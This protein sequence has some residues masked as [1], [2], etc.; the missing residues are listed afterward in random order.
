[1]QT[2]LSSLSHSLTVCV[3]CM[4]IPNCHRAHCST[5][6]P[7]FGKWYGSRS[8]LAFW[9]WTNAWRGEWW[10]TLL[11][12]SKHACTDV[13]YNDDWWY[14]YVEP[15][16]AICL[17]V[18]LGVLDWFQPLPC[19][20]TQQCNY[21]LFVVWRL[22]RWANPLLCVLFLFSLSPL[23][24]PLLSA[25]PLSPFPHSPSSFSP[26]PFPSLLSRLSLRRRTSVTSTFPLAVRKE[27]IPC[28][29]A[30]TW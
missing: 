3:T 26:P 21:D 5:H 30:I 20:L 29:L 17:R 23:L 19:H 24:F 22:Y 11:Q 7:T 2:S 28:S 18:V 27:E 25:S 9:C 8:L 13:S 16:P 12:I 4:L 15:F 14:N 1:M 10:D 6:V